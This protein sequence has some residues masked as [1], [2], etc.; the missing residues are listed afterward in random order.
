M[1]CIHAQKSEGID[2]TGKKS[3]DNDRAQEKASSKTKTDTARAGQRLKHLERGIERRLRLRQT[4][5]HGEFGRGDRFLVG[6]VTPERSKA[7]Q[8]ND[9]RENISERRM[10]SSGR[11]KGEES[12]TCYRD[13]DEFQRGAFTGERRFRAV[14]VPAT[15]RAEGFVRQV[16]EST[17][18][19]RGAA[20]RTGD[21]AHSGHFRGEIGLRGEREGMN[22]R[23]RK[24]AK[25]ARFGRKKISQGLKPEACNALYVGAKSAG[26]L[27]NRGTR[28]C[29]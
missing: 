27:N 7:Y 29:K 13:G 9:C 24:L 10:G 16:E 22:W 11:K 25:S 12:E 20:T 6:V 4:W 3:D 17:Q 5:I 18:H 28:F 1:P 2:Q 14:H 23:M 26:P 21:T 19:D 8:K 15:A